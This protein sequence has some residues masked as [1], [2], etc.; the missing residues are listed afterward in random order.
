TIF[1]SLDR[2]EA[3][4][5]ADIF[6]DDET[7]VEGPFDLRFRGSLGREWRGGGEAVMLRG[8]VIGIDVSEWHLPYSL[9][10]SPGGDAGELD[11]RESGASLALGRAFLDGLVAWD[12]GTRIEA[13]LRVSEAEMRTLVKPFVGSDRPFGLGRVKG[14]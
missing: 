7:L 11:V 13:H 14:R 8:K 12:G 9:S 10:F 2:G 1:V 4:Q 3:S 5:V 6:F